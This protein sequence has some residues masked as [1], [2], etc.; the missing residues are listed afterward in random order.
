MAPGAVLPWAVQHAPGG[1]ECP[2][3]H[4]T[5]QAEGGVHQR[6]GLLAGVFAHGSAP[7]VPPAGARPN[8]GTVRRGLPAGSL[9]RGLRLASEQSGT[10]CV[11]T[12]RPALQDRRAGVVR[13]RRAAALRLAGGCDEENSEKGQAAP[14]AEGCDRAGGL[15][16][17]VA[18]QK[19]G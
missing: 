4:V 3:Q 14:G 11:C 10:F 12:G 5:P 1:R 15:L 8:L 16:L 6:D 9:L 19:V 18:V 7:A 17:E 2:A 13:R